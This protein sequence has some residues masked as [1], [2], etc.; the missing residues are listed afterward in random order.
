LL[1]L[2]CG[3]V[4]TI[5]PLMLTAFFLR[6]RLKMNYLSICGLLSGCYTSPSTLAYANQLAASSAPIVAYASVYPLVMILRV[7]AAEL[8]I[9]FL[10]K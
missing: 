6:I 5:V 1:W 8:L 10:M 9:I 4:I 2:G 7:V 3:A